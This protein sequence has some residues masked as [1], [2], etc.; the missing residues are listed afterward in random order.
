MIRDQNELSEALRLICGLHIA[1]A[2][3]SVAAQKVA[4]HLADSG[5]GRPL[6]A[7]TLERRYAE[8]FRA[9]KPSI[10]DMMRSSISDQELLVWQR[11]LH[12]MP[13]AD[14]ERIGNRRS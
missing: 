1:G 4:Q 5:Q 13:D 14:E 7:S 3:V 12:D 11:M 8:Q 6:K 2:T 10:E 9:G